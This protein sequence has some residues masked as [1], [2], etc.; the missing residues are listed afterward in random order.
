MFN[1][2]IYSSCCSS[3]CPPHSR[4]SEM[5][6]QILQRTIP[7][8]YPPMTSTQRQYLPPPRHQDFTFV[9]LFWPCLACKGDALQVPGWKDCPIPCPSSAA[10]SVGRSL[11][12]HSAG[13]PHSCNNSCQVELSASPQTHTHTHTID[14][15]AKERR[16]GACEHLATWCKSK[17]V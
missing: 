16:G 1:I 17:I 7:K 11:I 8:C 4:V 10:I 13:Q 6:T 9:V 2:A 12:G 5:P 14:V 3:S 15:R